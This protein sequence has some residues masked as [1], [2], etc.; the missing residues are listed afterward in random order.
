LRCFVHACPTQWKQW[1][2]LA[3]FWYNSSYHTSLNSTPFEILYGQQPRHLGTNITESCAIPD[4]QVWL[5]ERHTM[6]QLL[7]QRLLRAQQCQKMQVDKHRSE[8]SF[9]VG[10]SVYLK[11]QPYV[12][13]S[14]A[15]RAS[16]KLS[17]LY[18]GPY[19]IIA[20]VGAVASWS[21][22]NSPCISCLSTQEG[23]TTCN[24][25]FFWTPSLH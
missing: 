16:H 4:L 12:Q 21:L 17:F 22:C 6:V 5:I 11:L 24:T 19:Q 13:S 10:D 14:I 18:F 2:A 15:T 20:K 3:K 1:L 8:R 23:A 25:S 9:E 7:Q